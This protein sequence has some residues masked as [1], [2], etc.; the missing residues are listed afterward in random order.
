MRLNAEQ[1]KT[2]R[3]RSKADADEARR[4][5]ARR[6]SWLLGEARPELPEHSASCANALRPMSSNDD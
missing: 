4:D 2:L 3:W 5:E 1:M 6:W